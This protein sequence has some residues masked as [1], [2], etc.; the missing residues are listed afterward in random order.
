MKRTA[1]LARHGTQLTPL[2]TVYAVSAVALGLAL[3]MPAQADAQEKKAV[4]LPIVFQAAGPTSDSIRSTVDAFRSALGDPDNKN[5]AG[6]LD[7]G[8]REINWDGGGSVE[9]YTSNS[10]HAVQRFPE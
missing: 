8:R 9:D 5:D 7:N 6:P 1:T 4:V 10:G 2:G 3:A